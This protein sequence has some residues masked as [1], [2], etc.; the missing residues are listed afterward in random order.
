MDGWPVLG[1]VRIPSW[2]RNQEA[3]D[4]MGSVN[5]AKNRWVIWQIELVFHLRVTIR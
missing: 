3:A 2:W 5:W 1:S 4:S